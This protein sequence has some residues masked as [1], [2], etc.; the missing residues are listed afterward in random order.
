L[1]KWKNLRYLRQSKADPEDINH[2]HISIKH[3][4]IEA[5]IKSLPKKKIQGPMDSLLNS[6]KPLRKN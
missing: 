4:E 3:N 1:K 2:L 5:A 6:T